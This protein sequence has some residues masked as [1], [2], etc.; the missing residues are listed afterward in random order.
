M[1]AA[2]DSC[3]GH[4]ELELKEGG[5]QRTHD[6]NHIALVVAGFSK[7]G[8]GRDNAVP[9]MFDLV[10][11]GIGAAG[12]SCWSPWDPELIEGEVSEYSSHPILS[13]TSFH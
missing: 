2:G 10:P 4:C 12:A 11:S 5:F 13:F 3:L 1:G 7:D 9:I 8:V 6:N